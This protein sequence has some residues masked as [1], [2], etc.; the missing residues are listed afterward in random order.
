[1]SAKRR[2]CLIKTP[3]PVGAT[4]RACPDCNSLIAYAR[5][6]ADAYD[7]QQE[8]LVR[9]V[10]TYE[11]MDSNSLRCHFSYDIDFARLQSFGLE[12]QL[13]QMV[14]P[15]DGLGRRPF[16]SVSLQGPWGA[17]ACLATRRENTRI[18][19]YIL[20]G[21]LDKIG[22]PLHRIEQS[23]IQLVYDILL[24][25]DKETVSDA[26][27]KL[28]A[29]AECTGRIDS[30]TTEWDSWIRNES[31]RDLIKWFANGFLLCVSMPAS[32]SV[33]RGVLKIRW[34]ETLS[35][36]GTGRNGTEGLAH[37]FRGLVY[38]IRRRL[39]FYGICPPV[40]G[41]EEFLDPDISTHFRFVV[42]PG[43]RPEMVSSDEEMTIQYSG[44]IV[45]FYRRASPV[46][47]DEVEPVDD[48]AVARPRL[49]LNVKRALFTFPALIGSIVSLFVV[50]TISYGYLIEKDVSDAV[51]I[52]AL[53]PALIA[54]YVALNDEHESVSV[55]LGFRRLLL[56]LGVLGA[57]LFA[58]IT[59]TW[60]TCGKLSVDQCRIVMATILL[61]WS[62]IAFFLF[63]VVRVE[64]WRHEYSRRC[65]G[66]WLTGLTVLAISV[67]VGGAYEFFSQDPWSY[68][69]ANL[70]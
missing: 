19:C 63:E 31:F 51:T 1:M 47:D 29:A 11:L 12:K 33:P 44:N 45:S 52:A 28:D 9:R 8:W 18:A 58:L 57:I 70:G 56:V 62:L 41:F 7:G 59:S 20:F 60:N 2:N 64:T 46:D 55:A 14:V 43:M 69:P 6:Y 66:A 10:R 61:E 25:I 65:R 48:Y 13:G 34:I 67:L 27:D 30:S 49:F 16:I 24:G 5:N 26:L 35:A 68:V 17:G 39:S 50:C 4:N 42:P 15:L 53:L 22:V 38:R 36:W 21:K 40:I 23:T 3:Q 54:S 32:R 37:G